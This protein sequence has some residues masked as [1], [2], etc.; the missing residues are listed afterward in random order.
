[1]TTTARASGDDE[2]WTG[3]VPGPYVDC[4]T[5]GTINFEVYGQRWG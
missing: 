1:M 3:Y 2:P 4:T 5:S